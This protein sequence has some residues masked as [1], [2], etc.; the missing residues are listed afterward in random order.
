MLRQYFMALRTIGQW[1]KISDH[2]VGV[3]QQANVPLSPSYTKDDKAK[4][5]GLRDPPKTDQEAD[6][7]TWKGFLRRRVG[8]HK[9]PLDDDEDDHFDPQQD[10]DDDDDDD[11]GDADHDMDLQVLLLRKF[12][13]R[14]AKK[15]GVKSRLCDAITDVECMVDWTRV[16]APVVEGRVRMVEA[17][18]TK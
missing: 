5:L 9:E 11:D 13:S 18:E 2:W 17:K 16:I 8:L 12:W 7:T 15:A 3:A 10:G 14:W 6:G 4:Q 1:K